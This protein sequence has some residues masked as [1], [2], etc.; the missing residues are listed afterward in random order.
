M[1]KKKEPVI[2][3]VYGTLK[4]G[5]PLHGWMKKSKFLGEHTVKGYTL[6]SLGPYP[7]MYITPDES[8]AVVGE[9]YEMPADEFSSLA[10]MEESTGYLTVAV[11]T[12]EGVTAQAFILGTI[13]SG[14][15]EWEQV[16]H[17]SGIIK[18]V[19]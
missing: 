9:L 8:C 3:F 12:T 10:G 7:A 6:L 17:R 11:H 14:A 18:P 15:V 5:C 19:K 13:Y 4:R 2:T 1:S 16:S